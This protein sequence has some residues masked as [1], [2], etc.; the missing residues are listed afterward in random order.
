M[1]RAEQDGRDAVGVLPDPDTRRLAR[2]PLEAVTLD[3]RFLADAHSFT[4]AEGMRIKAFIEEAGWPVERVEPIQQ[5]AMQVQFGPGQTPNP[6]VSSQGVGWKLVAP[7]DSWVATAVPG[8]AVVQATSYEKWESTFR[9]LAGALLEAIAE[10]AEPSLRQRIGLRYIDRF[11]E[12]G[13]RTPS[14]WIGR[15]DRAM[16]GP[17]THDLL[18]KMVVGAQQQ[19][20]SALG[21]SRHALLRHG[22]F[23][24]GAVHQAISYLLDTDVFDMTST[25]FDVE[26]ALATADELNR[27]ALALFQAA[28]CPAYLKELRGDR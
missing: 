18:G 9:P 25:A 10:V 2:P 28:I 5:H 17:L 12:A 4:P 27:D 1:Q 3:V 23:T 22:P 15:I 6:V 21:G 13:A 16:L 24:D 19:V 8:Q 11:V 7:G 20:E 14:D 26:E